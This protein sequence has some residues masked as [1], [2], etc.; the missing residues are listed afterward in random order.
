MKL[1]ASLLL[2]LI[3][4]VA[5]A[6]KVRSD[7]YKDPSY[8]DDDGAQDEDDEDEDGPP[9]R[10]VSQGGKKTFWVG[11]TITLPCEVENR[12]NAVIQ[13]RKGP[14]TNLKPLF[15]DRV[16]QNSDPRVS[17]DEQFGLHIKDLQ[18]NDADEYYCQLIGN[19]DTLVYTVE[20]LTKPKI[21]R[22]YPAG[23]KTL[24]KGSP[25]TLMCEAT[26][27]PKPKISWTHKKK[28][29]HVEESFS[30]ETITIDKVSRKHSGDYTCIVNNGKGTDKLT[31]S[32]TVEYEPEIEISSDIVHSG[33]GYESELTCVVHA[34]PGAKVTWFKNDQP[35][36]ESHHISQLKNGNSHSLR[37]AATKK[38]DFGNY[39]CVANN[40]IG[41]TSKVIALSGLEPGNAQNQVNIGL[42]PTPVFESATIAEDERS[43]RL[44][45]KVVSHSPIEQFELMYRKQEED[46]WKTASPSVTSEGENVYMARHTLKNLEQGTYLAQ[47][48]A[49]NSY[50]WSSLSEVKSFSGDVIG[51]GGAMQSK[52]LEESNSAACNQGI[53]TYLVFMMSLFVGYLFS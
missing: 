17:L 33:E 11:D 19:E 28:H 22:I 29:S 8:A 6:E 21:L 1:S 4:L 18:K 12:A 36:K 48:R 41:T 44:T 3:G 47:I 35:L 49:K 31:T 38:S 9:P 34:H 14:K 42:P 40:S 52:L 45:W 25:L 27:E 50:G 32:I 46:Q 37:I 5:L 51:E 15:F 30:E 24:K 53:R 2:M 26:G 20:V 7:D 10:I 13:W 16:S 23:S 43:P 39:K